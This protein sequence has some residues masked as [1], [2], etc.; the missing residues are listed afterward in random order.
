VKVIFSPVLPDI[1][2]SVALFE[3]FQSSPACPFSK[4]KMCMKQW[5]NDTDRGNPMCWE[6]NLSHG[7]T[8]RELY[9]ANYYFLSYHTVNTLLLRYKNNWRVFFKD[10]ITVYCE[11]IYS[12]CSRCRVHIGVKAGGTYNNHCVLE[13]K[14]TKYNVAKPFLMGGMTE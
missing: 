9:L 6:Q 8:Q 4:M 3:G 14:C 13:V 7:L 2:E 11:N 10:K 1:R 5:W 12:A